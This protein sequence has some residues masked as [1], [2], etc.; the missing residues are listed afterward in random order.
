LASSNQQMDLRI[1]DLHN[2]LLQIKQA[3]DTE[4]SERVQAN[5]TQ[6]DT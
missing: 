2:Q 4:V 1:R 5:Q 6:A 3:M